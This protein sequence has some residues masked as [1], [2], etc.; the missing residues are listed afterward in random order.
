[1]APQ[2]HLFVVLSFTRLRGKVYHK[3]ETSESVQRRRGNVKPVKTIDDLIR[4]KDL[5]AEEFERHRELIEECRARE[6][7]LKEYSRA[8]R[9]SMR[10]MTEELD[11][12]SR[13]AEE[14]WQEAQR[15]S[16]RV[17]GIYL[18]VAPAPKRKVYH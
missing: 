7:Q 17:N 18:H 2:N 12:M 14:L 3:R 6:V 16:Q 1:M 15:L 8:T 10:R 5:S 13:T 4:D 11:K 9:E